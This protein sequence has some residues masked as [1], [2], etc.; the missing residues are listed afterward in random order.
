L[1]ASGKPSAEGPDGGG[2]SVDAQLRAALEAGEA[3]LLAERARVAE[4]DGQVLTQGLII[5]HVPSRQPAAMILRYIQASKGAYRE[6]RSVLNMPQSA[7]WRR[8]P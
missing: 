2:L 7:G 5:R 4:L 1:G 6:C 8:R 3:A